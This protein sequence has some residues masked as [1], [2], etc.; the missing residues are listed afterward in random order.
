MTFAGCKKLRTVNVS[1]W[2]TSSVTDMYGMFVNDNVINN[3]DVSKWNT[4]NVTTMEIMFG[5]CWELE[6]LDVSKWNVSNVVTFER[7]LTGYDAWKGPD[8]VEE[9]K[10]ADLDFS[11]WVTSSAHGS[12]SQ[13]TTAFSGMF[14]GCVNLTKLDLRG[15][16]PAPG[17]RVTLSYMFAHCTNL[18]EVNLSGMNSEQVEATD[19][20]FYQCPNLKTVYVGDDW[21]GTPPGTSKNLFTGCTSLQGGAGTTYKDTN[22]INKTYAHV[23]GGAE[24]P[25]YF[26]HISAKT[27]DP[28]QNQPE[29][30]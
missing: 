11:N 23:D 1:N 19:Y 27:A 12:D 9:M 5:G 17:E 2:N 6:Y 14:S 7:F 24:N 10:I 20:A 15:F 16:C 4:S 30:N 3:L 26:T 8:A 22:P 21:K 18:V 25:G 29:Q 28:E 13:P